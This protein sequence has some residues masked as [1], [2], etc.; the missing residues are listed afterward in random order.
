LPSSLSFDFVFQP[1]ELDFLETTFYDLRFGLAV[2]LR[3][4]GFDAHADPRV[5]DLDLI[6]IFEAGFTDALTV[7]LGPVAGPQ[8]LEIDAIR[9]DSDLRMPA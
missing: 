8:I 5:T 9:S 3:A 6:A 2:D 1:L 7:E 4:C